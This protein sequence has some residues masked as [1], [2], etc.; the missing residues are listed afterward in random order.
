MK[1]NYAKIYGKHSGT[2]GNGD[3]S[4]S[5]ESDD[6]NL[7]SYTGFTGDTTEVNVDFMKFVDLDNYTLVYW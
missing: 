4:E 2:N 3:L 7:A 6:D 5:D 1:L